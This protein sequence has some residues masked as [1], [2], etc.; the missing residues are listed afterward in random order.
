[1]RLPALPPRVVRAAAAIVLALVM[2]HP[3]RA[4]AQDTTSTANLRPGA[5]GW[6]AVVTLRD[7]SR[8]Q[9]RVLE[10][11]PA[12][13]RFQSAL[14][15][16]LIPREAIRSVRVA[17]AEMVHGN[18]IWPEDPSRTRLFFAPT[19]RTL[20]DREAY[21]ADAYVFL[22]SFQL[23]LTNKLSLGAGM[24]IFPGIGLG[25]QIYYLTPKLGVYASP[26]LNVSVGA[27]VA[28]AAVLSDRSP[29]GIG[30]GVATFGGENANATLGG[31]VS[32]SRGVVASSSP[33]LL[34]G[35]MVRTSKSVALVSENYLLL[36]TGTSVL[37][38]GG[39][40]F[41]GERLSVDLAAFGATGAATLI[42]YVAFIYKLR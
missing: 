31:G 14:G 38:S 11:T 36:G 21:F 32:Y 9:G 2:L 30:Y 10:V 23:G 18:E 22:P 33:L 37:A 8:L 13:V 7:G 5:E 1:M 3:A 25:D 17:S 34:A 26:R 40:R 4:S 20:R 39:V 29:F 42:P 24:S 15:E 27:L 16:T 28:G 19:G 12:S 35:G 41:I 6:I